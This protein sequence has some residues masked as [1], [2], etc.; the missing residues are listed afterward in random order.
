METTSHR[1]TGMTAFVIVLAGQIVSL[2]GTAMSQFGLTLWAYKLT[3]KATPLALVGL[4]FVTP[5]IALA[6]FVG[7]LVDRG[8]R[9]L[10]MMLS[11]LAAAL[12][13]AAVLALYATGNLQIWHLYV[14]AA[15]TGTFQGF[16]WPEKE[17]RLT[18]RPSRK[19]WRWS[20]GRRGMN[21]LRVTSAPL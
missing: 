13:T 2:L 18:S 12:T 19:R 3:G 7:V 15:I 4:F 1:P 10:L 17:G 11:D 9:K 6:P 21:S 5:Q 16:Q 14:S 8:N 20:G